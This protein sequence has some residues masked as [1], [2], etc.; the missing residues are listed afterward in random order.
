MK[1]YKIYVYEFLNNYCYVGL[2]NNVNRRDGEHRMDKKSSVYIHSQQFNEE[3]PL[4]KIL[5]EDLDKY[6]AQVSEDNWCKYYSSNG[7]I[8]L[9]R[10]KTGLF[11]SSLGHKNV[12]IGANVEK[13]KKS[14]DLSLSY[15]ECLNEAKKYE[16]LSDFR[17]N[18]NRYYELSHKYGWKFEWLKKKKPVKNGKRSIKNMSYTEMKT[19]ACKYNT[20][21]EFA[22]NEK[23]LYMKC[24][25]NGLIDDFFPK[26]IKSCSNDNDLISDDDLRNIMLSFSTKT[27]FSKNDHKHYELCRNR[28]L[29]KEF[30]K[31]E[32]KSSKTKYNKGVVNYDDGVLKYK[33]GDFLIENKNIVTCKKYGCKYALNKDD[34]CLYYIYKTLISK[35]RVHFD[36]YGVPCY[37]IGSSYVYF[38]DVINNF[39]YN[40]KY[41]L[42][43]FK[44]GN[45]KNMKITNIENFIID[46]NNF[47]KM[48]ELDTF[49]I[50][51]R[52]EIYSTKHMMLMEADE[53]NGYLYFRGFRI[54]KLVVKYFREGYNDLR[55][56]KILHKDGDSLNNDINNLDIELKSKK[57]YKKNFLL[58]ENIGETN[59]L[60]INDHINN[61]KYFLGLIKNKKIIDGINVDITNHVVKNSNIEEWIAEYQSLDFKTWQNKDK[62]INMIELRVNSNGCYYSEVHKL[63]K[64][65]IFYDGKEYSLGYFHTFDAG[66]MLYDEAV[67]YIKCKKFE[68]WYDNIESHRE[69]MKYYFES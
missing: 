46:L 69:R 67:M 59:E 29:L 39:L 11:S 30:P 51:S 38:F 17:I 24:L 66:K 61:K 9:N 19:I 22:L 65:K 43:K 2:T 6:E 40:N 18:S 5:E 16:Y 68:Q 10:A 37:K 1:E 54:D 20:R 62:D 64:S 44:D 25:S 50:N 48:A 35:M 57:I 63:W 47:S 56:I 45:Y 14:S 21:T 41:N 8:L 60:Y 55:D 32:S 42:F 15:N 4:I 34:M 49:L 53:I 31:K 26:K 3:I 33:V 13:I 52:G 23:S 12:S 36:K 28:N 58:V 7:W 27:E